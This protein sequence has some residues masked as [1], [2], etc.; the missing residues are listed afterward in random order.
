MWEYRNDVLQGCDVDRCQDW[1]D[2]AWSLGSPMKI[3][4]KYCKLTSVHLLHLRSCVTF[5]TKL[6]LTSKIKWCNPFSFHLTSFHRSLPGIQFP[7]EDLFL[8]WCMV[9]RIMVGNPSAWR[10]AEE[11]WATPTQ[12][13]FLPTLGCQQVGRKPRILLASK[14]KWRVIW[15]SKPVVFNLKHLY[16]WGF[17]NIFPK[18]T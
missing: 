12:K 3:S 7:A 6:S 15:S 18:D 13:A 9:W 5:S 8:H 14:V 11:V 10:K 16:L 17:I 2:G 1:F 4:I